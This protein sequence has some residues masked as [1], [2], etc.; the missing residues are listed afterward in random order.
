MQPLKGLKWGLMFDV[1]IKTLPTGSSD[2]KFC[3]PDACTT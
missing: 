1:S 3:T 2:L